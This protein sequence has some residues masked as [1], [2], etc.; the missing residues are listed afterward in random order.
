MQKKLSSIIEIDNSYL[1][2]NNSHNSLDKIVIDANSLSIAEFCKQHLHQFSDVAQTQLLCLKCDSMFS[3]S[4]T[5]VCAA[6][7]WKSKIRASTDS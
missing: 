4:L 2:R 6:A 7:K 3:N 1:I 5:V